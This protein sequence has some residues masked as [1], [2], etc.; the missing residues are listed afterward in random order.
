MGI[1]V[2]SVVGGGL[3]NRVGDS[4]GTKPVEP[5]FLE[6]LIEI[7]LQPLNVYGFNL[8]SWLIKAPGNKR[9]G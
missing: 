9:R 4:V 7:I 5:R 8:M 1:I 2:G 6:V 3:E